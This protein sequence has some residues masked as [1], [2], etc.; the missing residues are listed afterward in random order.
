MS[1][2]KKL[3]TDAFIAM[4]VHPPIADFDNAASHVG[5]SFIPYTHPDV[6]H[7]VS[8]LQHHSHRDMKDVETNELMEVPV[9]QKVAFSFGKPQKMQFVFIE[10]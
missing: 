8:D 10:D 3:E 2:P 5:H 7:L 4:L 9:T 1:L 6:C